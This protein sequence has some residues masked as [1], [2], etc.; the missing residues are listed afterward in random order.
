MCY[1][2]FISH[3]LHWRYIKIVLQEY[4]I[5]QMKN[6]AKLNHRRKCHKI[7]KAGRV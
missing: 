6:V 3:S 5:K 1:I 7:N 4:V 2:V